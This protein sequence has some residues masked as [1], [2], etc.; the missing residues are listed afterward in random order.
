MIPQTTARIW[1]SSR[2]DRGERHSN[3]RIF[4]EAGKKAPDRA[5][6]FETKIPSQTTARIWWS[7][8]LDREKGPNPHIRRG[9]ERRP[10]IGSSTWMVTSS[11]IGSSRK[12]RIS[13]KA[14]EKSWSVK[15]L[16][17]V[18]R[19]GILSGAISIG[20]YPGFPASF[21]QSI[22]PFLIFLLAPC[23]RSFG[24]SWINPDSV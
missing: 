24:S 10:W 5:P 23:S 6:S 18:E 11:R 1:W 20:G 15:D 22:N 19:H 3:P 14:L 17:P 4:D 16:S 9:G 12:S 2:N 8:R 21:F 7:S 13:R